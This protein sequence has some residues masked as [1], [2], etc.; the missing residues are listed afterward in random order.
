MEKHHRQP[1]GCEVDC[2]RQPARATRAG[3]SEAIGAGLQDQDVLAHC[4]APDLALQGRQRRAGDTPDNTSFEWVAPFQDGGSEA[5]GMDVQ[6][7]DGA[8]F[9]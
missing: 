7:N 5:V 3:A 2:R 1:G 6:A 4:V 8:R 9:G